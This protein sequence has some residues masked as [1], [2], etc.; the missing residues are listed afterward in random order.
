VIRVDYTY[1]NWAD[2]NGQGRLQ[3]VTGG[4]MADLD[5]LQD[6]RYTY[7]ANGNVMTIQDYKAGN[8]QIQTFTYDGIDRLT[9]AVATGGTGD[10]YTLQNYTYNNTTGNLSSNAGVNYTYGDGNHDHAVTQMGSNTFAYDANGNQ[11][12][13]NVG[14]SSFTLSYEAENRLVGVSGAATASFVYDGDGNRI[15]G[16]IGGVTTTYIGNYFEWTGSTTTMIKYY[17]AGSTRVAMRTGS[18]TLN[19]LLGDH[20]GSPAITTDSS[21]NNPADIRYYPWGMER[22]NSGTTPTTYPF[23]SVIMKTLQASRGGRGELDGIF[24]NGMRGWIGKVIGR[25]NHQDNIA[26]YFNA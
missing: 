3:Q 9:S 18:S 6:L 17:Y 14:G 7:D 23:T 21:G 12:T 15:K 16:T 8:P 10:T 5:S 26:S 22:Y 19:Y 24:A 13:R 1:F 11:T 20:L 2:V 25:I 4:T